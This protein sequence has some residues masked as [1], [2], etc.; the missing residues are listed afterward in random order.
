MLRATEGSRERSN[1]ASMHARIGC[2]FS[3]NRLPATDGRDRVTGG[4][5]L[6]NIAY[7]RPILSCCREIGSHDNIR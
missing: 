7:G 6:I 5:G 2:N 1:A 3:L 4:S